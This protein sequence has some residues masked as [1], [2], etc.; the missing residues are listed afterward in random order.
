MARH[1]AAME[2]GQGVL[3][4]PSAS[5]HFAGRLCSLPGFNKQHHVWWRQHALTSPPASSSRG[6]RLPPDQ[7][8]DAW[9]SPAA[10]SS[11]PSAP[12]GPATAGPPL[13]AAAATAAAAP[14]KR[15]RTPACASSLRMPARLMR[16]GVMVVPEDHMPAQWATTTA[17]RAPHPMPPHPMPI[18]ALL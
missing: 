1:G 17:N 14:L 4:T 7:A 18:A 12:L 5:F 6:P 15:C 9:R 13:A 10:A 2:G 11:A 8:L 3:L 16:S